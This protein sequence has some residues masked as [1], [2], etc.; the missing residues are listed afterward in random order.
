[1][2]WK[3]LCF[4]FIMQCHYFFRGHWHNYLLQ[5]GQAV[6]ASE[7][8]SLSYVIGIVQSFSCVLVFF[9]SIG[10]GSTGNCQLSSAP[11]NSLQNQVKFAIHSCKSMNVEYIEIVTSVL[12]KELL[13][14]TNTLVYYTVDLETVFKTR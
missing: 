10:S 8:P 2:P 9:S 12:K 1:M 5:P 7:Q 6:L 14:L 3:Y 4:E 11:A 13:K